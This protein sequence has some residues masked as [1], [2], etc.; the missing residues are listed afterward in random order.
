M[1]REM[2]R[3]ERQ[4]TE[5][6][7]LALIEKGDTGMLSLNGENGYPYSVPVNYVYMNGA[8]YIHCAKEGRKLDLIK[9]DGRACFSSIVNAE[10]LVEKMTTA[11][12]SYIAEGRAEIV[13]DENEKKAVLISI[14][15]KLSVPE[16]REKGYGMVEAKADKTCIIKFVI[17]SVAGKAN[18]NDRWE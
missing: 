11:Y 10:V 9:K 16:F 6:Q 3:K 15:D 18:G 5:E 7:T 14:V 12:E 1:T 2:R 13:E 8:I 4:L 17:E